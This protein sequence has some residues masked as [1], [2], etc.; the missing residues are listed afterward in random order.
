MRS[1]LM[2]DLLRNSI[3]FLSQTGSDPNEPNLIPFPPFS[4]LASGKKGGNG[5]R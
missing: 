1:G 5:I 3:P 2:R 4:P